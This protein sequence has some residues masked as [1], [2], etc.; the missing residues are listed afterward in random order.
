VVGKSCQ[1]CKNAFGHRI[2]VPKPFRKPLF[3]FPDVV[4]TE[5][6]IRLLRQSKQEIGEA[7]RKRFAVKE[8]LG[9][10]PDYLSLNK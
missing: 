4:S 7:V 5:G 2:G 9:I 8:N 1:G 3:D 6:E 10:L